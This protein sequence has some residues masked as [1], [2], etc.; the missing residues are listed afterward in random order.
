MVNLF[1][2][3]NYL[4]E[5]KNEIMTINAE[6]KKDYE[7]AAVLKK[8]DEGPIILFQNV[9]GYKLK[10][11]GNVCSKRE[12]LLKSF[13]ANERNYHDI[14]YN[15]MENP[16]PCEITNGP[17]FN[18]DENL[19]VSD[20]PIPRHYESEKSEY[21]TSGIVVG[22]I[23]SEKIQNASIHRLMKIDDETF[24]IRVV[25]RHL[26]S[27][28]QESRKQKRILNIAVCIGAHPAV[29]LSAGLSPKYGYDHLHVA[30]RLLKGSLHQFKCSN[31][32]YALSECEI[33]ME[34]YIDPFEEV[35]EGPF[36]DLTGTPDVVRKQPVVH[37]KK[38]YANYS[39][40]YQDILPASNEHY[41]LMGLG[42]EV[43]I[44]KYVERITPFVRKV[45]LI[46]GGCGW[47][48]AIASV[49][50]IREGDAKNVIAACFAAHPSLKIAIVVDEDIDPDNLDEVNWAL[51]TRLNPSKGIIVINEA[52]VSSLDPSA[53]QEIGL[54]SKLG[55][56]ATMSF[57]KPISKYMRSSIPVNEKRLEEILST[58]R[59]DEELIKKIVN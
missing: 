21:I 11:V 59:S 8:L 51:A 35:D 17:Y 13:S 41:L 48:I 49:R 56:D 57:K 38:I 55:I 29:Y 53:D 14:I 27:M 31:G 15:A 3:K 40:I 24:G 34:G 22:R 43:M 16:L 6:V 18:S 1:T 50:K 33:I 44:Y 32:V 37:I 4:S 47:L 7:I 9:E 36:T 39:S 30:N 26:Y 12:R 23:E 20:L 28:I 25:P 19:R 52:T 45:R 5:V 42:R 58:A 46:K 2:L 10:V 54:G